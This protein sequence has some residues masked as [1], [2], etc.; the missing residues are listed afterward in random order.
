VVK[1]VNLRW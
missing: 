1:L